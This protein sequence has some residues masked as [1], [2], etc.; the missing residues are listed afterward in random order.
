MRSTPIL[1]PISKLATQETEAPAK[2]LNAVILAAGKSSRFRERGIDKPKVLMHLGGLRLLERAVLTLREAGVAHFRIVTGAYRDQV[3]GEM[4]KLPRLQGIDIEYVFCEQHE[5]GNGVTFAAG[6]AGFNDAFLLTMSDHVF[7]PITVEDFIE[8]ATATPDLPALAC[9]GDLEGIFDM[10][11]ATKVASRDGF[12][13]NIGKEIKEYDLVDT[14]LFYFP[15]GFGQQIAAKAAAGA[16]SVSGIIQ[17]FIDGVGVR[18]V[19]LDN[20]MWQDVDDPGMKAEAER[21]LLQ[22][23][24]RPT[25]GWV[26][27]HINRPVSTKISLQLARTGIHPN[28]VTTLVFLLSL[29]AIWLASKGL[30]WAALGALVFQIAALLDGCDGELARM[31]YRTTRFGAWYQRFLSDL[32]YLLFFGTIGYSAWHSTG[33][34]LF[35][36]GVV[37]IGAFGIYM[38]SQTTAV[39]WGRR[40]GGKALLLVEP[41][42]RS[43]R[44]PEMQEIVAVLRELMKKDVLALATL[45][46]CIAFGY[47]TAFWLGLA[48]IAAAAIGFSKAVHLSKAKNGSLSVTGQINP[49]Y[50]YLMGI[51]LLAALVFNVDLTVFSES[52]SKLGGKL[53]LV[54][55]LAILWITTNTLCTRTLVQGKVPFP[56][57]LFNQITGESYNTLLPLAAVGGEPYRIQHLTNW[58]D[59]HTASRAIVV[60]RLIRAITG[61]LF[62]AVTLTVTLVFVKMKSQYFIPL[63]VLAVLHL[64][65][66]AAVM[67]IALTSAPSKVVGYLLSK[68]KLVGEYRSEPIPPKRFFLAMSF[69]F[70]SRVLG[71]IE[72]FVIFSILGYSPTLPEIIT[73]AAF[74]AVSSSLFIFPQGL[75]VNEVGIATAMALL[76]YPA[77]I[78]ITYSLARRAGVLFWAFFGLALHLSVVVA[79]RLAVSRH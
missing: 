78:G 28:V 68:L 2:V 3:E 7:S 49:I 58:L 11:D 33:S 29:P 32:R 35:L 73:V 54:F 4:K 43:F 5:L 45:G 53:F 65:F 6:A 57:L 20:A 71:L 59:L 42:K 38:L 34:N 67:W 47:P 61:T 74:I 21:R 15:A 55:S 26:S 44:S 72:I 51:G 10:D 23:L 63:A 75:G 56:D 62:A 18:A 22:T 13:H 76:G 79:K 77:A 14:G 25:D 50:F 31:V 17:H 69:K 16:H 37:M 9:D 8:K 36:A 1:S 46:L 60:D 24:Y 64:L 27:R 41:E 52:L 70:L 39:A 40:E 48:G 12:I 66:G 19:S 30:G